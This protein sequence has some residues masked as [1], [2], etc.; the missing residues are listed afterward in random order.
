MNASDRFTIDDVLGVLERDIGDSDNE[1]MSSSEEEALD[2]QFEDS[3]RQVFHVSFMLNTRI[4][5]SVAHGD[6]I[7]WASTG[8][9]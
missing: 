9:I 2:R 1:G 8:G 7:C 4:I 6:Q 5:W 3:T